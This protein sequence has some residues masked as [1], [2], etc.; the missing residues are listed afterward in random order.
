MS[1]R[2]AAD[3]DLQLRIDGATGCARRILA[4]NAVEDPEDTE[5]PV[6]GENRSS[7]DRRVIDESTTGND[8][9][10][11]ST[12]DRRMI[13]FEMAI[14][15]RHIGSASPDRSTLLAG[16]CAI[17]ES[18]ARDVAGR[19]GSRNE[20]RDEAAIRRREEAARNS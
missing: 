10:F 15:N 11:D 20:V 8:R 13:R 5:T 19:P 1:E 4:E 2:V 16:E 12:M 9:A 14:S 3:F 7:V 6:F 17:R 18:A